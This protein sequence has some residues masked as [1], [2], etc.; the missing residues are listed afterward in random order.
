MMTTTT[1]MHMP[2]PMHTTTMTHMHT[3]V[4]RTNQDPASCGRCAFWPD[5]QLLLV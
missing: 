5:W 4:I 3:T 1:I 2:Q